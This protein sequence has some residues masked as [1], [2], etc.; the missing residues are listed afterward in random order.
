MGRW[1]ADS[2]QWYRVLREIRVGTACLRMQASARFAGQS[3]LGLP[4]SGPVPGR[5]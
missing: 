2:G 1:K 4:G 5:I 3:F